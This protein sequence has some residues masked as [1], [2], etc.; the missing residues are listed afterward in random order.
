MY[1]AVNVLLNG[2]NISDLTKTDIFQLN[3]SQIRDNIR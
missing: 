3:L 1:S 2:P